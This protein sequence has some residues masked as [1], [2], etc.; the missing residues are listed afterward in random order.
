MPATVGEK[1]CGRAE[2]SSVDPSLAPP[3]GIKSAVTSG[4]RRD[5]TKP[6]GVTP[7]WPRKADSVTRRGSPADF[8]HAHRA[9]LRPLTSA[10]CVLRPAAVVPHV[11]P[12]LD[13]PTFAAATRR[14]T[15]SSPS[16]TRPVEK[17][18]HDLVTLSPC[19]TSEKFRRPSRR[20]KREVELDMSDTF[21]FLPENSSPVN[22]ID[23]Y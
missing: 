23:H 13:A 21:P 6:R 11:P 8:G 16:G 14:P 1:G 9:D 15:F 20:M 4:R 5:G 2:G 10:L 12:P 22:L 19:L 3:A 17:I 18:D 7:S